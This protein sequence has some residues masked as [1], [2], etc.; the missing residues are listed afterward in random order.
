MM[1]EGGRFIPAK[2]AVPLIVGDEVIGGDL[3]TDIDHIVF[4]HAELDELALGLDMSL[5]EDASH[6]LRRVL[7]LG[8]A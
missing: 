5:S 2:G 8:E 1:I 4:A 7:H 3:G 6:G